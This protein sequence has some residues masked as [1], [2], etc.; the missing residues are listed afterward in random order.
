MAGG[1]FPTK[2]ANIPLLLAV[3]ALAILISLG[4]AVHA[5]ALPAQARYNEP[6]YAYESSVGFDFTAKVYPNKFYP[7]TELLPA[8]LLSIR[9]PVEPPVYKRVLLSRFVEQLN[10]TMPYRFKGDRSAPLKAQLRVDGLMTLPGLWQRPLPVAEP[11]TLELEG[12]E[13]S[14][15]VTFTVLVPDLLAEMEENRLQY[16]L[17]VEPLEIQLEPVFEVEVQGLK[18][19]VRVENRGEFHIALRNNS[20]EIDDPRLVRGEDAYSELRMTPTQVTLPLLGVPVTV[21]RMRQVSTIALLISLMV[22]AV[23]AWRHRRRT[24]DGDL[25][26]RLGSNL[27]EAAAFELPG[28]TALVEIKTPKELVQLQLQVQRPVIRVGSRYHLQ[29]GPV[30]YRYTKPE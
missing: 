17:L 24:G 21:T 14:G 10:I 11:K 27:I 19:P 12:D 23:F 25:L 16:N 5:Y 29:D 7:G 8:Q 15:T 1:R 13:I 30:C 20:L 28:G 2:A 6:W 26:Q 22:T 18:Q 4:S 3:F 9:G